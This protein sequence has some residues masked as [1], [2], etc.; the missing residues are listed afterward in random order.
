MMNKD[1]K[2]KWIKA[3][4]SGNY[5]Q[6]N[7]Q[8]RSNNNEY[9]SLGVLCDV[10]DLGEWKNDR[11]GEK[12]F[13]FAATGVACLMAIPDAVLHIIGLN[14]VTACELMSMNDT[15]GKSFDQIADYIEENV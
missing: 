3:L 5:K 15:E 9:C 12:R 6:G 11:N 8:L 10:G 2:D 14:C 7:R 13:K 1:L 4:R